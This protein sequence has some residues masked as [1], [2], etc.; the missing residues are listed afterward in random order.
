MRIALISDL[1]ANLPALEAALAL[2]RRE[3]F[4]LVVHTGDA[5]AIGPFT[6]ECIDLLMTLD[7]LHALMGN[8]ERYIIDGIPD[9]RPPSISDEE[10]LHH[11]WVSSCL[12][13]RQRAWIGRLPYQLI[14]E[15]KGRRIAFLHSLMR[16]DGYDFTTPAELTPAGLDVY[17]RTVDADPVCYGHIH[18]RSIVTGAKRYVNP[19]SLGCDSSSIARVIMLDVGADGMEVRPM[20]AEYDGAPVLHELERRGVPGRGTIRRLLFQ[21]G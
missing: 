13:E 2:I 11:D 15:E 20:E 12:D 6:S 10:V 7:N 16:E 19:G 9:P 17:F 21:A 8:H 18:R 14:L 3:G 1:H 5:V 4:D